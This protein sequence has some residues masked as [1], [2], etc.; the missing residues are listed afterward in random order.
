MRARYLLA[1]FALFAS[2]AAAQPEGSATRPV[3]GQ[4]RL[5]QVGGKVTCKLTLSGDAAVGGWEARAPLACRGAFPL[6]R[7][8]ASWS[9]DG[10]GELALVDS[11]GH[12]IAG[13][14]PAGAAF[15]TK[16][17]DGKT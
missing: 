5:I 6:L 14:A 10:A 9:F 16:L 3:I 8:L 2:G 7:Q 13:F 12:R 1:M 4:W 17:P 15:E 11:E